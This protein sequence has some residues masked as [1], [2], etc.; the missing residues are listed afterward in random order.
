VEHALSGFSHQTSLKPSN[1]S[2]YE[3]EATPWLLHPH[4]SPE[5]NGLSETIRQS[6]A[7]G[8]IM[9]LLRFDFDA[10]A[11]VTQHERLR[12]E[13]IAANPFSCA[14]LE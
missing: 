12:T 14:A 11:L 1:A 8:A 5:K 13:L 3:S 7:S 6:I 2:R 9:P 10:I 4:F